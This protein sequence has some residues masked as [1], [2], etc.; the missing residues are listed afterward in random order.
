MIADVR[1]L[2]SEFA[3][4]PFAEAHHVAGDAR[5][6]GAVRLEDGS[7]AFPD[8]WATLS[9]FSP[10]YLNCIDYTEL[11]KLELWLLEHVVDQ[12]AFRSTRLGTLRSHP[13]VKFESRPYFDDVNAPVR[14]LV[15]GVADWIGRHGARPEVGRVV[16]QYFEDMLQVWR[17]QAR[18]LAPGAAAVCV[19][20]NSTFSRRERLADGTYN[21]LWRL[22]LLTDVILCKL[23]EIAGF[24]SVEIWEAREL[25]PRNVRDGRARE[26]LVV[27]RN[28]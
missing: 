2:Q 13:S 22:P 8:G 14:D 16:R 7:P 18:V 19:V 15:E 20:A 10:P 27:A 26:S 1:F 25:R 28:S 17:E 24:A 6:L 21:E 12:S 5:E 3:S 9:V 23:A 11:Y 4:T